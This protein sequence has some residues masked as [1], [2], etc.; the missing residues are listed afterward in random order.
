MATLGAK[1]LLNDLCNWL[2]SFH[3]FYTEMRKDM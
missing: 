2:S 1:T 3:V